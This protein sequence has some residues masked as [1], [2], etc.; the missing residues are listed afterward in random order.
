MPP[1]NSGNSAAVLNPLI[2]SVGALVEVDPEHQNGRPDSNEGKAWIQSYNH[3]NGRY[4]MQCCHRQ[5]MCSDALWQHDSKRD[6][7]HWNA[8]T[9]PHFVVVGLQS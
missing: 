3:E 4:V 1:Q 2:H 7:S 6:A 8:V 9:R 5:Y